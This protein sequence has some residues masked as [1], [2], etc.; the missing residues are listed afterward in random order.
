MPKTITR[1]TV[2]E[3]QYS[4]PDFQKSGFPLNYKKYSSYILGR[5]HVSGF[6]YVM[7]GD[8]VSGQ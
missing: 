1:S 8:K 2:N 4:A 6:Q 5:T 3:Q 7:P